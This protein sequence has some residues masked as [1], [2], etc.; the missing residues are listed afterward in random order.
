[1]VVATIAATTATRPGPVA[2]MWDVVDMRP[3][4]GGT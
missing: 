2:W 4:S 3:P 1:M